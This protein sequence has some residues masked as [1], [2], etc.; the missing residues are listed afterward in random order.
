MS[1]QTPEPQLAQFTGYLLR[2]AFVKS[3]G[4]AR[5]CIS[6]DAQ[7]REVAV[8]A[9]LAERG[10]ISQRELAD[11]THV[12]QTLIVKLVDTLEEKGW[13]ARQR[14]PADRRSYA[15]ALTPAGVRAL[16]EFNRD[17]DRGEAVLTRSLS[18]KEAAQLRG[19]LTTLLADDRAIE[20]TSLSNRTGYLI[21][22]AHRQLRTLA[23]QRLEPLGLQPRDFGVLAVL[24]SDAPCSQNHL[25]A[26]LGVSPPAALTFVEGLEARGLVSRLRREDDRRVY[27]LTLTEQGVDLLR[28]AKEVAIDVQEEVAERLGDEG[29]RGLRYVL[30]KLIA[31][32]QVRPAQADVAEAADA[33]T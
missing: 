4:V 31:D 8:L 32:S 14:N 12:N 19:W 27:D 28:Q 30:A 5:A 25:A 24:E 18:S 10:S 23:E 13:A 3:S 11:L 29:D 15:L 1:A 9:I 16:Y 22:H 6:D 7:I 21:A 2:R 26:R 17:L 33:S 20:L